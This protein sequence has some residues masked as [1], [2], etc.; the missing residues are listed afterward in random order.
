MMQRA[1][2]GRDPAAPHSEEAEE[3]GLGPREDARCLL[4]QQMP[5]HLTGSWRGGPEEVT[6]D[7]MEGSDGEVLSTLR[8]LV[9]LTRRALLA[10]GK[11]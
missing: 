3:L 6:W 1:Q 2:G 8:Y 10:L 7:F 5:G 11:R 9:N 4:P